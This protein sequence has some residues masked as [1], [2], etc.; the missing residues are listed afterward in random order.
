MSYTS[1]TIIAST[2]CNV[3]NQVLAYRSVCAE[4]KS[5]KSRTQMC[6]DCISSGFSLN[7]RN[8]N[9]P[10]V[11]L[12][13]EAAP[14]REWESVICKC[15]QNAQIAFWKRS[16]RDL[17]TSFSTRSPWY[18]HFVP[19]Y[20]L[21]FHLAAQS[22]SDLRQSTSRP[23]CDNQPFADCCCSHG[24]ITTS[25]CVILRKKRSDRFCDCWSLFLSWSKRVRQSDL[26]VPSTSWESDAQWNTLKLVDCCKHT[27]YQP[28]KTIYFCIMVMQRV[29]HSILRNTRRSVLPCTP[30]SMT[31]IMTV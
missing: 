29:L 23:I 19:N 7:T 26:D 25:T 8:S 20:L 22:W 21:Q 15:S 18:V 30:Q 31:K 4:Q 16:D 27:T 24:E 6:G 14:A 3:R 5:K 2:H 28:S 9:L 12:S 13:V 1:I 10:T 17:I 11:R